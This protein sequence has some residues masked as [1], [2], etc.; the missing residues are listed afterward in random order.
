[1]PSERKIAPTMIRI[2]IVV[3]EWSVLRIFLNIL[4]FPK[5]LTEVNDVYIL[6]FWAYFIGGLVIQK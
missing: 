6:S 2:I 1:M 4:Y 3:F 5:F